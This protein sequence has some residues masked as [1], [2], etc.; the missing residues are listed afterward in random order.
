MSMTLPPLSSPRVGE[1]LER[2]AGEVANARTPGEALRRLRE[3][4]EELER[5]ERIQVARALGDGASFA[6]IA[7]DLGVSRQAVHRRFREL[8]GD[9]PPLLS[10]DDTRRV[11]RYARE[12]ALATGSAVPGGEHILLAVL[13]AADLPASEV[14]RHA[15]ATLARARTQVEGATLRGPLFHRG[16]GDSDLRTLLAAPAREARQRGSRR[17]EVEHLLLGALSDD[18]NGA[19]RTLGALGVA[20]DAVRDALTALLDRR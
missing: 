19:A 16:P 4:R 13:R 17:I 9:E 2:L 15:G 12:E 1:P 20:P 14:L 7:R 6:T 10:T 5:F 3:L 11:L 8:A 18:A